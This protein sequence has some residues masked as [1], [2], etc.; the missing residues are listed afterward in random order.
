MIICLYIYT[1]AWLN[2]IYYVDVYKK[3][4]NIRA[5]VNRS[6]H[7]LGSSF[8]WNFLIITMLLSLHRTKINRQWPLL[9]KYALKVPTKKEVIQRRIAEAHKSKSINC[10]NDRRTIFMKEPIGD[11]SSFSQAVNRYDQSSETLINSIWYVWQFYFVQ[12]YKL[13]VQIGIWST[14][15]RGMGEVEHGGW[16]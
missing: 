7:F 6:I 4:Q 11:Q 13:L 12:S 14:E 16:V 3:F 1:Y 10:F 5:S 9:K 8:T 2:W 15:D